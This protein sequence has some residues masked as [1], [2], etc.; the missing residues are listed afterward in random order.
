MRRLSSSSS[1]DVH[2]IVAERANTITTYYLT[3]TLAFE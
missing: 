3:D 1:L 2:P